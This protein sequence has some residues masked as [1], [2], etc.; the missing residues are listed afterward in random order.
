MSVNESESE[1]QINFNINKKR[2]ILLVKKYYLIIYNNY[3][4]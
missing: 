2:Q 1:L 4:F 3:I